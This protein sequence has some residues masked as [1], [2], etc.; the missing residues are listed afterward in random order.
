M[1][2]SFNVNYGLALGILIAEKDE[3]E[4]N[5]VWGVAI[6]LGPITLIIEKF[7]ED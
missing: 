5:L 6:L 7:K 2:L 4:D 1:Q 3:A